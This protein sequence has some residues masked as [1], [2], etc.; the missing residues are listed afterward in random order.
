MK[1]KFLYSLLLAT[2]VSNAYATFVIDQPVSG[3]VVITGSSF[4]LHYTCT[5]TASG[6]D[7][8]ELMKGNVAVWTFN[9]AYCGGNLSIFT[10]GYA[11]GTDYRVR[12]STYNN[13]M[14]SY[15]NYFTITPLPTP[16]ATVA[17]SIGST[18]FVANCSPV[19][20]A[21][22]YLLD[23]SIDPNFG[24]FLSA[25]NNTSSNASSTVS[26][27]INPAT[28]YYYR[29]RAT[30]SNGASLS[31]NV[32]SVNTTPAAPTVLSGQDRSQTSFIARWNGSSGATGYLLDV[33]TSSG[34]GSYVLQNQ[35]VTG[36]SFTVSGIS[37]SSYYYYRV[38]AQNGS[39]NS[40]YSS[41]ATVYPAPSFVTPASGQVY[42]IGET[43]GCDYLWYD[44]GQNIYGDVYKG[45]TKVGTLNSNFG[46]AG[47]HWMAS[48]STTSYAPG[49]DYH[50]YVY[51][52][53]SVSNFAPF[54]SPYFTIQAIPAPVATPAT[55][56]GS[57]SFY[58]NCNPV[59][60][61]SYYLLDVATDAAFT[62]FVGSYNSSS[63]NASQK[64]EPVNPGTTYY[65]R[66]RAQ[67][68]SVSGYSNVI[69][70]VTV[71]VAPAVYSADTRG[72]TSAVANW[73]SAGSATYLLDISTSNTFSSF[74]LQNQ[75]VN[76]TSFSITGLTAESTYYYR[77]RATNSSGT[78]GYSSIITIY[79][80][81]SFVTPANGQIYVNGQT[82]SCDY[83][84][85]DY[86][87]NIY[88]DVYK[89]ATKVGTLTSNFASISNH[90]M[91]SES[92]SSYAPGTDYRVYVYSTSS[93]S[94]FVPF[95]SPY[96]TIQAMAIPV[97]TSATII[98][99][100]SFYANCN[101]VSGASY[102]LL[103]VATDAGFTQIAGT[104]NSSS[105][106][107][108][109]KV[110]TGIHSGTTYYYRF[111]AVGPST[112]GYSN[113]ISIVTAPDAP[114]VY[115][116]TNR[117]ATFAVANWA[118]AGTAS[119]LLDV[120]TSNTFS[121][122]ILQN[123]AVSA[124][125]F[126][127]T[128]L[129]AGSTYYY[130]V[131]ATNI[132]GTSGYSST[133]T[134]YPAPSFVTPAAGQVYIVGQ[135]ISCDYLW[136]DYGQDIYGDVYKGVTKVGTLNS[137]FAS[138]SNHW[139]ALGSP[140][141]YAPGTDYRIYVYT[142]AS[143]SRFVP[144]WSPYFTI[145]AMP[146]PVATAATQIT[147]SYFYANCNPVTPVS[148]YLLDVSTNAGFTSFV[149]TYNSSSSSS[150]Q[151]V[152]TGIQPGTTYYYRFRA[153]GPSTSG[154]SNTITATTVTVA[155]VATAATNL[156]A[157]SF[158]ANWSSTSGATAY[159]LDVAT[160]NGFVNKVP[161]YDNLAVTGTSAT[162]G[163]L[164]PTQPHYYRVRA[165]NNGGTSANSNVITEA[166]I[167]IFKPG[168]NQMVLKDSK[169]VISFS[170]PSSLYITNGIV[171]IYKGTTQV[172][173][174]TTLYVFPG[175]D[176][177]IP[178]S[179]FAIGND[180]TV[181]IRDGYNLSF[182]GVSRTFSI[183]ANYNYVRTTSVQVQNAHTDQDVS[184][185]ARDQKVITTQFFDGL[186]RSLQIVT[187]NSSPSHSDLVQPFVYDKF[188]RTE[189][190]YLPYTSGT[191][192][193][194]KSNFV[195]Q[196]NVS[197]ASSAQAQFYQVTP[198][199]AAST[200]PYNQKIYEQN[201]LGQVM[202]EGSV[203]AEWQPDNS[204]YTSPTD[205]SKAYSSETNVSSEV[206]KWSYT[207]P[208]STYPFGL[209]NA[210]S[211]TTPTYYNSGKL[212]KTRIK[213]EAHNESIEFR[214]F[215]GLVI[216][217]RIVNGSEFADVYYIYDDLNNLV[218]VVPP[219]AVKAIT[220]LPSDYFN[221]TDSQKDVFLKLWTFRYKFDTRNRLVQKHA[222]GSD[223][224]YRIYD[225]RDRLILTQDGNQRISNRWSFTKYD[226][227]NRAIITG[228]KDTTQAISPEIMQSI[229]NTHFA[230]ASARW[231]ESLSATGSL[232]GYSNRAYPVVTDKYTCLSFT[233]YDNYD[234]KSYMYGSER[235][236]YDNVALPGEQPS[237]NLASV[238]NKVTGVKVKVLDGGVTGGITWLNSVKY[239]DEKF[240]VIQVFE[241]NYVGGIDCTTSVYDFGSRILKM[242]TTHQ[243]GF[244]WKDMIG[245][246]VNGNTLASNITSAAWGLSGA[247]S[248]QQLPG[249]QSGW[250]EASFGKNTAPRMIGLSDSNPDANYSTIDYAIYISGSTLYVYENNLN[251]GAKGTVVDT[252]VV[253]VERIGST[254][255]YKKNAA[256]VYTSTVPSTT[257][258]MVDIA[259]NQNASLSNF[260]SSFG[261]TTQTV[262]KRFDYDH[263]GRLVN[264]WHKLNTNPEVLIAQ[265]EYNELGQSVSKKLHTITTPGSTPPNNAFAQVIDYR[266]NIRGWLTRINNSDLATDQAGDKADYFGMDLL[267]EQ[268]DA[269]L[270]NQSQFTGNPSA[271]K[272]S[273]N[274]G[275]SSKKAQA[276]NFQ[277]DALNRMIGSSAKEKTTSWNALTNF[278]L[279]ESFAEYDLNGNIKKLKRNDQRASGLMD[280]LEY[281]YTGNK[282]TRVNDSGDANKGFINGTNVD[283]E[284]GYDGNGNMLFDL[285]N[286]IMTSVQNIQYNYMNLPELI[287]R[288]G[289]TAR[290][291]YDAVG[292]KLTQSV[293]SLQKGE[294]HTD[295]AG[296]FIYEQDVLQQV[297]HNEG[298]I[299]VA[300]EELMYVN[301]GNDDSDVTKVNA[302]LSEQ[303]VGDQTYFKV[304][305]TGPNGGLFPMGNTIQVMPGERYKVRA[306]GYQAGGD[307]AYIR[308]RVNTTE[309]GWPTVGLAN[310]VGAEAWSELIV[311]IP[312]LGS[313]M[314]VGVFWPSVSSNTFYLNE[315]EV[316]RLNTVSPEYQYHL[317]D[318]LGNIRST[319]T[320]KTEQ[321][322]MT[323]TFENATVAADDANFHRYE[324]AKR[325]SSFLFDHTSE[326]NAS[327]NSNFQNNSFSTTYAPLVSDGTIALSL[328][329]GRLKATNA[330]AGNKVYLNLSTI[331]GK[332]YKVK[333]D[334][335]VSGGPKVTAFAH[336][337]S[338][339]DN[340]AQVDVT[341]NSTVTY[342]FVAYSSSTLIAFQNGGTA[343]R[344]FYLDNLVIDQIST[345]GMYSQRL[346]GSAN[347]KIGL[348]KSFSVMPGDTIK[349]EVWAKY[350]DPNHANWQAA[351]NMITAYLGG[352]MTAPLGTII[353]GGYYSASGITP[354]GIRPINHSTSP[355]GVAPKAYLNYIFIDRDFDLASLKYD[356]VRVT[357]NAIEDGSDRPHE[358]LS[359]TKVITDPGYVYVYLS[360]DNEMVQEVY[361]DD[362]MCKLGKGPIVKS[363]D[364]Y[365][366]GLTFNESQQENTLNQNYKYGSK[367]DQNALD[368]GWLDFGARM[369]KPSIGRWTT[370]DPSAEKFMAHSAYHYA[371][372]N[373]LSVID[374]D[375]RENVV[376]VGGADTK[377]DRDKFFNTALLA[378]LDM[379][380]RQPG[381][382]STLAVMKAILTDDE[383]GA[384]STFVD[385]MKEA[386]L[387]V[388]LQ[389]MGSADELTNYLN[390]KDINDGNLSAAREGDQ[391]TDVAIFGHGLA[392]V[393]NDGPTFEPGHDGNTGAEQPVYTWGLS[394]VNNLQAGAFKSP[395]WRFETCNAGTP[396]SSDGANLLQAVSQQTNGTA[397]GWWGKSDYS[398]IYGLFGR[399]FHDW[400]DGKIS[401]SA[402]YPRAGIKD[403][404]DAPSEK[405]TY[406]N[407]VIVK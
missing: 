201:A 132:S 358:L 150:S 151:K 147:T 269:S 193:W 374:P 22:Y 222:P 121:S 289:N 39:G 287:N 25:Y 142:T 185:L 263:A 9:S 277:Y 326:A 130:R 206:L 112:S 402:N 124:T 221:T 79:P 73:A 376:V 54:W 264:T 176:I 50:V 223:P 266:Y 303:V 330:G 307:P 187:A 74:V 93:P 30:G 140:S 199:V 341:T 231:G 252:D 407:G 296:D 232:F 135:T 295:Y 116:A 321:E 17:T 372:N 186:G 381:E 83:L 312:P 55:T 113:V 314:Q 226:L 349:A 220:K 347:E 102:Y 325:V 191:D 230:K 334:I 192:S 122:F 156:T 81:P 126:N 257:L 240:R 181:K 96:F 288:G 104:Y 279:S 233:Y 16:V 368:L 57:S 394:Q 236:A 106:N 392:N 4:N 356:T 213:D 85:S 6:F 324:N 389:E 159:R 23:V 8:V 5:H 35:S 259:F 94:K 194:Y 370:I 291:I 346:N 190:S 131:R 65:Y 243:K 101:P 301:H 60:G 128:G 247:A 198:K 161:G 388:G 145:Q 146:T 141:S 239:Y 56:I 285:N 322:S 197:Y 184:N 53:S 36:T 382:L 313:T 284:Y 111:R 12:V 274:M 183:G 343:S 59:S 77:V 297:N 139:M 406:Q 137:N 386:G 224:V 219:E 18:S 399:S 195:T 262:T 46:S 31:S 166:W 265:N 178:T 165:Q 90:W 88:G 209:V 61:A 149:G 254:V 395:T 336:E 170:A 203:G 27:G 129:A 335:D 43:I 292:R 86:G 13:S 143:S 105:S 362:F 7:K 63:S 315:L 237:L 172:Y 103:D 2:I 163:G 157:I 319:F 44:Y 115:S 114:T 119:Y 58:A 385:K 175:Y 71:P 345:G 144:F 351:L 204:P 76:G 26:S 308:V 136:Q 42:M 68:A 160:D 80:A 169:L 359:L 164:D 48:G 401:P 241:D 379:A 167:D 251:L 348:A 357:T 318:H 377:G 21:S 171:E 353:D 97:A 208:T 327:A 34:F 228:I 152:E 174:N 38:R 24:S 249:G 11:A 234:F 98:G 294:Q 225:N 212:Y 155:P 148:Y 405:M 40:G 283:N 78:S 364:Y 286:G 180:Y 127:L 397:T 306:K 344:D 302:T 316:I 51:S 267:Y 360:N 311:T 367:E 52:T 37:G 207:A 47:N 320:T 82:I 290:N 309:I 49:A 371:F 3:L 250:V 32:I 19:S 14:S 261:L 158:T 168:L 275:M 393:T 202:K 404:R 227:L 268:S 238:Y 133:I 273:V 15:S 323:A 396:R 329:S 72:P 200:R 70:T 107:A 196:D 354:L 246:T 188:G 182:Y 28:T 387:D 173:S 365:P 355:T 217:K 123:Q 304:V 342:T 299:V 366:F 253:R 179:T 352:T 210:S 211:G 378:L 282:V 373:P 87:Q 317:K 361:F 84:W 328:V 162:V 272:W 66:F 75:S 331:A 400:W 384:L 29:F 214:N 10:G 229:V 380:L 20:G 255:Y 403:A 91:A 260:R 332:T 92:S 337:L 350:P 205:H 248:I 189:F 177:T 298:R 333:C 1:I 258:L 64:I 300:G 256:I 383:L 41:S 390:S 110:E 244:A 271:V 280:D 89:A 276:Y 69:S 340:I 215:Q 45:V 281:I 62:Q 117:D 33:S 270:S 134:I 95:W 154:Y 118:T 242:K 310:R 245:I 363:Q 278:G 125:N 67:G 108:S 109:Q 218:C 235:Y 120:S 339:T 375:G 391:V 338:V 293:V 369:Y 99:S 153:V 138:I 216:L 305:N 398:N 100:T